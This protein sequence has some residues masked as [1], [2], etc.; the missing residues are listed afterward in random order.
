MLILQFLYTLILFFLENERGK[1][2][3]STKNLNTVATATALYKMEKEVNLYCFLFLYYIIQEI[4]VHEDLRL[5]VRAK[6]L[7][8]RN[9]S[10]YLL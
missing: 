1:E 8:V 3:E 9:A 7:R 10:P 4:S 2:I 5:Q 6:L